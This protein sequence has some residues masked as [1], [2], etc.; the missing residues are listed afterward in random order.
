MQLTNAERETIVNFNDGEDVASVYTHNRALRRKLD[1]LAADR[2]E[3]CKLFRVSHDGL[4]AEFYVPKKWIKISPPRQVSQ[5]QR[6]KMQERA[7]LA[8][9]PR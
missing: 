1:K 8:F 4:A 5:A 2:P 3:D 9:S 7:K 6:E